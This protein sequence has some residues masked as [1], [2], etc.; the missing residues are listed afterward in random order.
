[1]SLHF[2]EIGG[3]IFETVKEKSPEILIVVGTVA[4]GAGI[5]L[6]CKATLKIDREKEEIKEEINSAIDEAKDK[7]DEIDEGVESETLKNY[8]EQD[9]AQ[10]K[11]VVYS[12]TA[13]SVMASGWKVVKAYAPAA[14]CII[15]GFV[16]IIF[17]HKILRDRET[18]LLAAYTA[19]DSAF[20]I[21]RSRVV[22]EGGKEM[23]ARF[24]Y[25]TKTEMKEVK[26]VN[27]ETGVEETVIETEEVPDYPLGSPY[28]RIYDKAHSACYQD[29][30]P[31]NA[32]NETY[33]K[34]L[35][36]QAN[37][38]LNRRGYVFLNEVYDM[39]CLTK[40]P[41]GQYVGWIKDNPNG[42]GYI[43]FGIKLC[44]EDPRFKDFIETKKLRRKLVLDFNVDGVIIDK[45]CW[46]LK[47]KNDLSEEE[48]DE[49][50]NQRSRAA[51]AYAGLEDPVVCDKYQQLE[52][53]RYARMNR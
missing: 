46:G 32:W 9:A 17:S 30:D 26:R 53:E 41:E 52:N 35:Q 8:D 4:I 51:R 44:Y 28:A 19:L 16:C 40:T 42:D 27:P 48:L 10:D 6:A 13:K 1:M 31:N 20:K 5:F 50:E 18:T 15:L 29:A 22:E 2:E 25:G 24:L 33:L 12:R 37:Q 49:I 21:Y 11:A 3:K 39:L 14:G 38:L 45:I 47:G 43:D 36:E 23:D 34:Q 7:M